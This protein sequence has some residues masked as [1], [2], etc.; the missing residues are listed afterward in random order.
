L[1]FNILQLETFH[2]K[3]KATAKIQR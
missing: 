3:R 2:Q 1:P